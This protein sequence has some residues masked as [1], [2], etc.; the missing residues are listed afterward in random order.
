MDL[1]AAGTFQADN[2]LVQVGFV[3]PLATA[4]S[5]LNNMAVT[6]LQLP[7]KPAVQEQKLLITFPPGDSFS[8]AAQTLYDVEDVLWEGVTLDF[9]KQYLLF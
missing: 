5:T 8:I 6:W 3:N 9:K 1:V 4:A 2:L 7:S